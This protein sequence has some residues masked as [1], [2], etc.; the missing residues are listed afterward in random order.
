MSDQELEV[1]LPIPFSFENKLAFNTLNESSHIINNN[2]KYKGSGC[3]FEEIGWVV[4]ICLQEALGQ[5]D[6][7]ITMIDR[8]YNRREKWIKHCLIIIIN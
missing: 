7:R 5:T 2:N 4:S 1:V 6:L 3:T 8:F